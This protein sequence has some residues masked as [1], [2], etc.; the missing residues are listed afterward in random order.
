MQMSEALPSTEHSEMSFTSSRE[1][2][3]QA[4]PGRSNCTTLVLPTG[5]RPNWKVSDLP[6]LPAASK[7][8]TS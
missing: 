5:S 1:I 2:V 3:S 8:T 7:V 4:C 6:T